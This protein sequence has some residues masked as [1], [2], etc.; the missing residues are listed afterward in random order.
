MSPKSPAPTRDV[1]EVPAVMDGFKVLFADM[2]GLR[3]S[4]D[5]IEAEGVRR[6]RAWAEAAD[7]RLWVVDQAAP[8]DLEEAVRPGDILV[9]NKADLPSGPDAGLPGLDTVRVSAKTQAGIDALWTAVEA[10][11]RVGAL[12]VGGLSRR[13]APAPPP[14]SAATRPWRH[15]GAV[16]TRSALSAGAW[17]QSD[18]RHAAQALGRIAGRIDAEQV[19]WTRCSPASASANDAFHVEQ[20]RRRSIPSPFLRHRVGRTL[21]SPLALGAF[22]SA[23]AHVAFGA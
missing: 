7:L 8:A 17:A 16:S 18:L 21:A 22:F 4:V 19:L 2:A 23:L 9:L 11:A 20:R 13:H 5:P 15:C 14:P 1:I 6:A 12:I 10:S 3:D